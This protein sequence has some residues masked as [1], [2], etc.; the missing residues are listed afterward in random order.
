MNVLKNESGLVICDTN[1]W[2]DLGENKINISQ[3]EG[4]KLCATYVSLN[5]LFFS[6]N[7]ID[8]PILVK[9]AT[10]AL[11]INATEI[12][13]HDPLSH[14]IQ[15]NNKNYSPNLKYGNFI[16]EKLKDFVKISDLDIQLKNEQNKL[17][18]IAAIEENRDEIMTT[19]AYL[20][21]NLL[22]IIRNNL[23]LKNTP[24]NSVSHKQGIKDLLTTMLKMIPEKLP[25]LSEYKFE[26]VG[27]MIESWDLYFTKLER[28]GLKKLTY[29]DWFDLFN[30]CYVQEFDL[31]ATR[32]KRWVRI[33][34]DVSP[35]KLFDT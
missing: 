10:Q 8:N 24:H 32:D 17:N 19:V 35:K 28:N 16:L 29:N 20:N 7:L 31:Y 5:E 13:L 23:E 27:L 12:I 25:I 18:L 9:M 33:I 6:P 34:K 15:L 30:L 22:P 1:I 2:Y 11:L 26:K 4:Y 21:E 14:I 3:F